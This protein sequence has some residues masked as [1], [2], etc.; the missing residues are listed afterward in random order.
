VK[1]VGTG[2]SYIKGDLVVLYPSSTTMEVKSR[3]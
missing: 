1:E 2:G 3:S